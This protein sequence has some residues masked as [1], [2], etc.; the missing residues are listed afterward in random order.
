MHSNASLSRSASLFVTVF[1]LFCACAKPMAKFSG[2]QSDSSAPA[3]VKFINQSTKA[4]TYFWDFGDGASSTELS[5]THK[6]VTS[7]NYL[8]TLK[9]S[10]KD[11]IALDSNWVQVVSPTSCMV[12]ISTSLG[13]IVVALSD[14]T[15]LHRDNFYKLV[16][17][18]FYTDLLFHRVVSGF[19][20]QGGDPT[21][22]GTGG[23]DYEI[24][25]EFDPEL[26][27][28]RG[29]LAAARQP[30]EVNP[31]RNSNGSQFYIV[32]GRPVEDSDIDGMQIR[33]GITYSSAT[34]Q[35]YLENGGLPIL[36]AEYTVFGQVIEGMDVVD[37]ISQIEVAENDRP[38]EDFKMQIHIIN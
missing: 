14:K 36:D 20:V 16:E 27:H 13:K 33:K 24:P 35:A 11:R 38:K 29:A 26:A 9:A 6:Y 2:D 34:R 5:P 3:Y 17:E 30:D 19:V 15:P 12:E 32:T 4:D 37:A 8:V 10:T 7:G 21:G 23:P 31:D 1:F 22:V 25:A 28:V 18:G